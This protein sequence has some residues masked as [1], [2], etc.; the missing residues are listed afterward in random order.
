MGALDLGYRTCFSKRSHFHEVYA[1][2]K[3]SSHYLFKK[4]PDI[5]LKAES[6]SA[7]GYVSVHKCFL[8]DTLVVNFL[9][10]EMKPNQNEKVTLLFF[11]LLHF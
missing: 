8:F 11:E 9:T 1:M 2:I 3:K 7:F 6:L 4:E 5:C 10:Y